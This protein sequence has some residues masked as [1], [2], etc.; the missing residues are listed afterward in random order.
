MLAPR[1]EIP[2]SPAEQKHRGRQRFEGGYDGLV[3]FSYVNLRVARLYGFWHSGGIRN[4]ARRFRAD[5]SAAAAGGGG[6]AAD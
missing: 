1:R 6:K 3:E 2:P 4:F 5:P